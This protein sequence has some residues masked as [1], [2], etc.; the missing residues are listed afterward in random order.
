METNNQPKTVQTG[1]TVKIRT[2][3]GEVKTYTVVDSSK[4]DPVNGLIS[5][6]CPIGQALM[7]S[8]IGEKKVYET[9]GNHFEI[10]IIEIKKKEL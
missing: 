6:A 7:G 9:N 5:N 2:A 3:S 4:T 8:A 10:E 1:D